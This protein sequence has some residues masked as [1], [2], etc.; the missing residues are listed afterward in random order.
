MPCCSLTQDQEA[1]YGLMEEASRGAHELEQP[2]GYGGDGKSRG[3]GT[4]VRAT[5]ETA[6]AGSNAVADEPK[7]SGGPRRRGG[8]MK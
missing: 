6:G 4:A 5:S 2:R 8:G 7:V 1:S 3:R